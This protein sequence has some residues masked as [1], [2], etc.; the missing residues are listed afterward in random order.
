MKIKMNDKVQMLS[1]TGWWAKGDIGRIVKIDYDDSYLICFD[2][3]CT[4]EHH[5]WDDH[6][7][8]A[9]KEAFELYRPNKLMKVE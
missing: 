4:Q 3:N 5:P 2:Q 7:W 9:R 6:T 1:D 8:F